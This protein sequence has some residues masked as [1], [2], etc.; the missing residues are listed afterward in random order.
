MV[1]ATY[2]LASFTSVYLVWSITA[3]DRLTF[4]SINQSINNYN[5]YT[6]CINALRQYAVY[7][8]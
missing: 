8:M 2:G 5:L 4:T 7:A 6:F 1:F 3:S